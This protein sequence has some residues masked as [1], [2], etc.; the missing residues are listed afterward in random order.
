M[1]CLPFTTVSGGV[2]RQ[3]FNPFKRC[4]GCLNAL[5]FIIAAAG[6]VLRSVLE[7]S[8][9]VACLTAASTD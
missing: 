7:N 6:I 5:A 1:D 8:T 9:L 3:M 4:Y 2:M